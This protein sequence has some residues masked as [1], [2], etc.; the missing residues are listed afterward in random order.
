MSI[1][2]CSIE[3]LDHLGIVAGVIKDLKI[4]ELINDKLI[5]QSAT[6]RFAKQISHK[7]ANMNAPSVCRD[8]LE[9]H[10]RKIAHSYGNL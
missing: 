9:N 3:R 2:N 8:L 7:Y 1:T 6:P 4:I 5:I 10:D